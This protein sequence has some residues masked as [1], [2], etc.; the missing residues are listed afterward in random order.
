MKGNQNDIELNYSCNCCF[1]NR[2]CA[3][4]YSQSVRYNIC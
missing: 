4:G 1:R 3:G 2:C